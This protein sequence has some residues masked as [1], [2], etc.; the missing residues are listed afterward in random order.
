[1]DYA[2]GTGRGGPGYNYPAGR[3]PI[4]GYKKAVA[5]LL[6]QLPEKRS[7][8]VNNKN[9]T[10]LACMEK[11]AQIKEFEDQQIRCY[12]LL[13][14][15]DRKFDELN[16]QIKQLKQLGRD[17]LFIQ[18]ENVLHIPQDEMKALAENYK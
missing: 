13:E 7:H 5:W 15:C 8:K 14:A 9:E 11:D 6:M 1:M 12:N 16:A 3:H 10:C 4:S 2:R 17:Q 18:I